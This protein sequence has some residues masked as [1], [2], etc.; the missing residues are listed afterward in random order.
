[1]NMNMNKSYAIGIDINGKEHKYDILYFTIRCNNNQL[2]SLK[3]YDENN[4]LIFLHCYNNLLTS[5]EFIEGGNMLWTIYC[6]IE[7]ENNIQ[8][9]IS[10]QLEHIIYV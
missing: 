3:I 8:T 5:I 4:E 2:V 7:L 10:K 9:N 6:D 1:M